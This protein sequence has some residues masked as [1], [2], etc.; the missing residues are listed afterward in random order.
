M[1][2]YDKSL[3]IAASFYNRNPI[4]HQIIFASIVLIVALRITYLLKWSEHSLRIPSKKKS[5]IG[6]MF[7]RGAAMFALGFCIWNMD[8]I[9]CPTLT[10]WKM[11]VGWPRAFFLEG[12][13]V[14]H[15]RMLFL[16]HAILIQDT[17]GGMC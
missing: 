5:I 6:S 11:F 13:S 1:I 4:Y 2:C 14:Y 10:R 15:V 17:H 7:S 12:M 16:H 3:T 8:N 9:F